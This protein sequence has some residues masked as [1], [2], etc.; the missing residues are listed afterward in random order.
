MAKSKFNPGDVVKCNM[1]TE[2]ASLYL[3]VLEDPS[4]SETQFNAVVLYNGAY[5][6]LNK[7]ECAGYVS[8]SW[9]KVAFDQS[10]MLDFAAYMQKNLSAL[11]V[12]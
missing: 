6:A 8:N 7:N 3:L 1:R 4:P 11:G 5:D 12:E 10:S 9:N 2:T